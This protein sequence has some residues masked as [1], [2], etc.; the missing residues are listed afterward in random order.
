[1]LT[2]KSDYAEAEKSLREA[3]EIRRKV[4][5]DSS[6]EVADTLSSPAQML[7]DKGE[8]RQAEPLIREALAIRR[9]LYGETH[10]DIAR[11][12]EDLG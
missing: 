3:L 5:G 4:F 6:P 1:M 9:K 2:L 7:S 10:P 11:S 12:I 8:P